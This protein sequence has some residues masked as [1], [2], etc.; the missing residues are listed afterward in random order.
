[1][2]AV[3]GRLP[4]AQP[5]ARRDDRETRRYLLPSLRV[6]EFALPTVG[7]FL[8]LRNS[9]YAAVTRRN[10]DV[11][12]S[13]VDLSIAMGPT[14]LRRLL[15]G[16]TPKPVPSVFVR[17]FD[18]DRRRAELE[19]ELQDEAKVRVAL[20]AAITAAEDVD[21][22][23]ASAR[24]QPIADLEWDE[25]DTNDAAAYLAAMP[26]ARLGTP[27]AADWQALDQIARELIP[28]LSGGD[29]KAP[30]RIAPLR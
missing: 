18:P 3:R 24:V 14:T 25:S 19:T 10:P 22:M 30:V 17:G 9:V 23:K 8:E 27:E 21:A 4:A 15:V 12:P 7:E 20:A 26:R 13:A 2:A 11:E 29:P 16:I 5:A 28:S 1:M 6:V